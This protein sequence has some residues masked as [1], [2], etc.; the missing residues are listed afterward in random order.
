MPYVRPDVQAMLAMLAAAPGPRIHDTDPATA[1]MMARTMAQVA[2]R[3]RGDIA[4]VQDLTIPA[5]DG[6]AIP[7]RLYRPALGSEPAPVLLWLHGGGWVIGDLDTY[8]SLCAEA[9]RTLGITVLAVDY[10][11][12][13]EVRFPSA[14]DDCIDAAR[15]LAGSPAGIGHAVTGLVI[16]G[17]S[18]GGNLT[19]VLCQEL[20]DSLAVPIL[21][22]WLIYPSTDM[23]W[24][25]GSME[26]FANGYLLE[27]RTMAW[28]SSHYLAPDSD[29]GHARAAPLN[30]ESLAGQPSA[31][32]FT[33][34]LDPLRD[35]G[36][37]Y[38]AKLITH[39]VRTIF[40]EAEGQIHG[41]INNR[42]GIPS[43]H[44]DLL[45]C[46][47]D[48]KLLIDEAVAALPAARAQAAE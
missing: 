9:A 13:P 4:E 40:R 5:A 38:A 24:S 20:G 45:A 47:K 43:A 46:L 15:W 19:A 41:S 10:R 8:D 48:L 6:H 11:M 26:E 39:G 30:A 3:P 21:A 23:A 37:A 25:H 44:D 2:E 33:C 17:D 22:Q 16:G 28:F 1:R 29:L 27:A 34:S 18:A 35:Q 7:L 12:G 36:R 14:A 42:G 31:L 32:V